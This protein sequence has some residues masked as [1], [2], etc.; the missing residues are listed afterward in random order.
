VTILTPSPAI[1]S[2]LQ[3]SDK[4]VLVVDS[5]KFTETAFVKCC[6]LSY[7]DALVT[8]DRC[9][10]EVRRWLDAVDHDVMSVSAGK[11]MK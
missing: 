11:K 4:I 3:G 9:P 5:S 10:P 8:D 2:V 6:S 1:A 7:L